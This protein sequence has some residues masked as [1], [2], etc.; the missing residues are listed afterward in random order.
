MIVSP[1]IDQVL[2]V[3]AVIVGHDDILKH[4]VKHR[5]ELPEDDKTLSVRRSSQAIEEAAGSRK[6]SSS[7]E[8]RYID[9]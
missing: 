6:H 7:G 1:G 3:Y 4:S 8:Y 5:P 2:T 9:D